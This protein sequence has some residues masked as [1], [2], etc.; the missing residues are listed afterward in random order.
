MQTLVENGRSGALSQGQ[1]TALISLL[2]DDDPAI[3]QMVRQK[4]LSYGRAA[5]E[6]LRPYLLSS[7]P[8]MRRR[9]LEIVHH[10]ARQNSDEKFLAFCLNN[11]EE[12]NLETAVGLLAQTQYPDTNVQAYQA[13]Y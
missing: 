4:I 5:C 7:D 11:G 2:V 8:V 10:L 6:W 1:R 12:L 13:L 9:A 3:Y